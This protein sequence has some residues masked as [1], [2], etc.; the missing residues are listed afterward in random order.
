MLLRRGYRYRIYPDEQTEAVLYE[1]E[2]AHRFVWNVA[3][4][5]RR[6][7]SREIYLDGRWQWIRLPFVSPLYQQ[8]QLTLDRQRIDWLRAAPCRSSQIVL[9]DL[10]AAW[11]M[12]MKDP[13]RGR[14]QFKGQGDTVGMTVAVAP[15]F[16]PAKCIVDGKVRI[17]KLGWVPIILHRPLV[18]VAK[19]LSIV[20]DGRAWYVSILCETDVP[21]PGLSMCPAVGIDRGVVL[22][23]ADSDGRMAPL[24]AQIRSLARRID[25][26]QSK[27]DHR[28]AGLDPRAPRSKNWRDQAGVI[29]ELKGRVARMRRHWLHAQANY[30]A[31]HYGVAVVED[32]KIKN[33]TK[34]ARG[35]RSLNRAILEQGWS[36]FVMMLCY[37]MEE[38]GGVVV[39]VPAHYTS[40]ECQ[41]CGHTAAENRESQAKFRCVE[42]GHEDNADVNAAKVILQRYQQGQFEF[43]GGYKRKKAPKNKLTSLRKQTKITV[44][45]HGKESL[46]PALH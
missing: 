17:P 24:P 32:L 5:T 10:D 23:L 41:V 37:K 4:R 12:S 25:R 45:P 43:E 21:D 28:I 18:G 2:R 1:W 8:R 3:L 44:I 16:S 46:T 40:Q 30:Y 20:R 15:E 7:R 42:C 6:L 29:N 38:R 19:R 34:H 36:A 35:K 31:D 33:M 39:K 14:P 13:T 22:N 11:Q 26:M 9:Q 27:N